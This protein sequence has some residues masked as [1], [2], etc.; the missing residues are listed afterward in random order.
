MQKSKGTSHLETSRSRQNIL[1]GAGFAAFIFLAT[2]SIG[3]WGKTAFYA[4]MAL[5]A[6]LAVVL[7]S[8]S[9]ERLPFYLLIV[10]LSVSEA[11]R[12]DLLPSTLLIIP[13]SLAVL[14]LLAAVLLRKKTIFFQSPILLLAT[15]LGIW[16]SVAVLVVGS[17]SESRPYWLVILL[18]FLVPNFLTRAEHL[19]RACWLF[20]LPLGALGIYVFITRLVLYLTR[21]DISVERLHLTGLQAFGDKNIIGLWITLGIPFAYYLFE[22]YKDEPG[23]RF[24]LLV[25]GVSMLAG[26][27]ATLSVGVVVGLCVMLI[28][29]VWLQPSGSARLR[30]LVL[31]ICLIPLIFNGF[32]VQRLQNSQALNLGDEW[33][34]NRGE[35]WNAGVRTILDHPVFGLGLDPV[36]RIAFMQYIHT[37]FFQRWYQLGLLVSPHSIILEVG[38]DIGFPGIVLYILLMV[39]ILFSLWKLRR[40][41]VYHEDRLLQAYT[42]IFLVALV[43]G[44]AQGL[45]QNVHLDKLLWFLMGGA[46]ALFQIAKSKTGSSE[47]VK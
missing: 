40:S 32:I 21:Q 27:L 42:K 9:Y 29:I 36:R 19:L 20:L 8:L 30:F 39:S 38:V 47:R 34:S 23:K 26:A 44:W 41:P 18:L 4:L 46:L 35:L 12:V 43:G 17:L 24:W 22:Y 3:I 14:S 6:G 2:T 37:W 10:S 45:A 13:G 16:A 5:V 7:L 15:L 11:L 31:G 1:L 25:A 28:L 33:A